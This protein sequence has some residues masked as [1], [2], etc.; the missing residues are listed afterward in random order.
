MYKGKL[1]IKHVVSLGIILYLIGANLF[2]FFLLKPIS[3]KLE[4]LKAQKSIAE[5]YYLLTAARQSV[6][7]FRSRFVKTD[8]MDLVRTELIELARRCRITPS[9]VD[10]LAPEEKMGWGLIKI[11][12]EAQLRGSYHAIG[13]FVARLERSETVFVIKEL[14]ISNE[15]DKKNAHHARLLLYAFRSDI[16]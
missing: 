2:Y 6:K 9:S 5:D 7:E 10:A 13:R 3:N 16:P 4:T 8:E 15:V 14:H 11:P 1:K 12:I